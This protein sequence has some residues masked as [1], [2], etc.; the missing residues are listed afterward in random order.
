MPMYVYLLHTYA[1]V[2]MHINIRNKVLLDKA[3]S[4]Q[5][6]KG[7]DRRATTEL[8]ASLLQESAGCSEPIRLGEG[9]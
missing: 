8:A 7:P 4:V 2:D 6:C 1:N 5:E 9:I 3:G